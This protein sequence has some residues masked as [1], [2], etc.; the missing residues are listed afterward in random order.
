ML[1]FETLSHEICAH[2]GVKLLSPLMNPSTSFFV[3]TALEGS[4]PPLEDAINQLLRSP[5]FSTICSPTSANLPQHVDAILQFF[6][7]LDILLRLFK[8]LLLRQFSA[9]DTSNYNSTLPVL[10]Q[11][12]ARSLLIKLVQF[13]AFLMA[14]NAI[15]AF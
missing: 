4:W 3:S 8:G 15:N 2:E 10:W 13:S 12:S 11:S 1:I 9:G 14:M 5:S 6:F 7:R